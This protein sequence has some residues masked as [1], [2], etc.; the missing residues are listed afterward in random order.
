[1]SDDVTYGPAC[2]FMRGFPGG[3]PRPTTREAAIELCQKY[4]LSK[5]RVCQ[6]SL[7]AYPAEPV[8][9]T[10]EMRAERQL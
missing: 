3:K 5:R 10:K 6:I 7:V 9:M 4:C 8:V 1:M 2:W